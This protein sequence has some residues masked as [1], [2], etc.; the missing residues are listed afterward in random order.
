[1]KT[2]AVQGETIDQVVAA[3]RGHSLFKSL[4]DDQLRQAASQ[5]SLLQLEP[6]ESLIK[7]GVPPEGFYLILD[8]ELR[9]LMAGGA[10]GDPVE[11]TRFGRG[12]ML[13]MASLLLDAGAAASGHGHR[14][15]VRSPPHGRSA[16]TLA[17]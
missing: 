9:V 6:G 11:V 12:E 8:G 4:S 16:S 17:H 2:V 5:A 14:G 1:M 3:T 10:G 15:R 13:D 7:Q